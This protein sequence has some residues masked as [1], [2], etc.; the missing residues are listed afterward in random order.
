[1]FICFLLVGE[2]LSVYA[3]APQID[4]IKYFTTSMVEQNISKIVQIPVDTGTDIRG[5][6][7]LYQLTDQQNKPVSYYRK[8]LKEICFDGSCRILNV[9]LYWNPTGRY[10]GFELPPKEFLS[11]AEHTPFVDQDY[12]QLHH[13]LEDSLSALGG[14]RYEELLPNQ[15]V[16]GQIDAVTRP[17]SKDVL[18]YVVQ[19]AVFTTYSMWQLVYGE[20]Q[21]DV[22][23]ATEANLTSDL[24]L[25]ILNS[26]VPSDWMWGLDR[27]HFST[28]APSVLKNKVL[29]FVVSDSYSLASTAITRIPAE[30]CENV[31]F[32][33]SLWATFD[34]VEYSLKPH[35]IQKIS[36]NGDLDKKVLLEF[37]GK[38]KE[39]NGNL[40]SVSLKCLEKYAKVYP[41][42]L[43]EI[44]E[45]TK[46]KNS[47]VSAQAQK[48]LRALQEGT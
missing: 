25:D 27:L 15:P 36:E 21:H 46:H 42:I 29:E 20:M 38:L 34:D 7:T 39:F 41:Q 13:I 6:D 45:L 2:Q 12:E 3:Q 33:R 10:L 48:T 9:H 47:Y 22:V 26:P 8:I 14:F 4:T 19:G 35:L 37:A 11:K 30:W 5:I 32:Q 1:M 16:L 23:E 24:L 17:T 43:S 28:R 40:L 31:D 18:Q 44:R